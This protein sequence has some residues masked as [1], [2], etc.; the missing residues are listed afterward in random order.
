[1]PLIG[2]H[3]WPRAQADYPGPATTG[4]PAPGGGAP[5][6]RG[7]G[8]RRAGRD[9]PPRRRPARS[10]RPR[11]CAC[12][13]HALVAFSRDMVEDLSRAARLPEGADVPPLAG[14][15]HP[16]PGAPHP[17]RDVPA[18][19]GRARRPA[20]RVVRPRRRAAT[21]PAGPGWSA[22]TSPA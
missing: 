21:R 12:L 16:Q 7:H 13:G 11:T 8:R 22:T 18:V 15:P 5:D 17:G 10:A 19:H 6:D 2:P 3:R 1:M 9:P 20:D 14:Q 4:D